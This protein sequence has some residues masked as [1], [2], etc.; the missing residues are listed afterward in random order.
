MPWLA[1]EGSTLITADIGAEIGDRHWTMDD[2]ELGELCIGALTEVV[3]SA[4]RDYL[5]CRVVAHPERVPGVPPRVRSRPAAARDDGRRRPP[6]QRRAQRRVRP[7]PHGGRVLAHA[8][9]GPPARGRHSRRH[10]SPPRDPGRSGVRLRTGARL[11]AF[12]CRLGA[13]ERLRVRHGAVGRP[14]SAATRS[15]IV[16][17]PPDCSER[18]ASRPLAIASS[19]LKYAHSPNRPTEWIS[20]SVSHSRIVADRRFVVE[21]VDHVRRRDPHDLV[22]RG[23]RRRAAARPSAGDRRSSR[24]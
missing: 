3:P 16:S 6:P 23:S 19:M 20:W 1:P 21:R 15:M 14:R 7:H 5:G 12:G 9:A 8:P 22:T 10:S 17:S 24:R 2:G 11:R 4:R 13:T 18:T